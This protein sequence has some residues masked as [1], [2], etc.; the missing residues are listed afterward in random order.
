MFEVLLMQ[1][2]EDVAW[3]KE[4]EVIVGKIDPKEK[5]SGPGASQAP[6]PCELR[7]ER[8]SSSHTRT[9]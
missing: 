4:E 3:L 1:D 5:E 9:S 6:T 2:Y 8:L 7:P